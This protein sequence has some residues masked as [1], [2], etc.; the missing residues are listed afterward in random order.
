MCTHAISYLTI[1][2][3]CSIVKELACNVTFL[4]VI[5]WKC[6][7]QKFDNNRKV[8]FLFY[9]NHHSL[10]KKERKLWDSHQHLFTSPKLSARNSWGFSHK[11]SIMTWVIITEKYILWAQHKSE[12]IYSLC[13]LFHQTFTRLFSNWLFLLIISFI[14][15]EVNNV[16]CLNKV[17][18]NH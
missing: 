5:E 1:F 12:T 16:L 2:S 9:L 17:W 11:S 8:Y 18:H 14:N 10:I 6:F 13:F 3:L 7:V 4:S 15:D